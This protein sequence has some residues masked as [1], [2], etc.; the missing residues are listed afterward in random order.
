MSLW[1]FIV[2]QTLLAHLTFSK[3]FVKTSA[4]IDLKRIKS[5]S[6]LSQFLKSFYTIGKSS[7]NLIRNVFDFLSM[8]ISKSLY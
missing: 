8:E 1:Q 5:V 7:I 6:V 2:Q 4:W 3:N